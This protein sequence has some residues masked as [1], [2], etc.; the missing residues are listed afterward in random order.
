MTFLDDDDDD[1]DDGDPDDDD[2]DEDDDHID[3][4]DDD[5]DHDHHLPTARKSSLYPWTINASSPALKASAIAVQTL[6]RYHDDDDDD[7]DDDHHHHQC[8]LSVFE[9]LSYNC[10]NSLQVPILTCLMMIM[11]MMMTMMIIITVN[12][13]S[14]SLKASA[15]TVQKLCRCPYFF[16]CLGNVTIFVTN[17][18]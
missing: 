2:D 14:P 8:P 11:M 17:M 13:S 9:S 12:A 18:L 16:Q 3:D 7:D 15:I 1:D 4:D 10:A 6:C 5:D